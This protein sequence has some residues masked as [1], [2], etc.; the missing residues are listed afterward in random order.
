MRKLTVSRSLPNRAP[1]R[2]IVVDRQSTEGSEEGNIRGRGCSVSVAKF[3]E[4]FYLEL[5]VPAIFQCSL[6]L[7]VAQY[8]R[9]LP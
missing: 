4:C 8:S 6:S 2:R 7:W 3:W 9:K 5:I 1:L